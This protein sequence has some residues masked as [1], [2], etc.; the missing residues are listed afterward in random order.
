MIFYGDIW[1][2]IYTTM[3]FPEFSLSIVIRNDNKK[4]DRGKKAFKDIIMRTA[5]MI[6]YHPK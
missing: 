5:I 3:Y 2:E 4:S 1:V 6:L